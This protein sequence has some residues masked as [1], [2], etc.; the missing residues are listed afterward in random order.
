MTARATVTGR[1]PVY[2]LDGVNPDDL[3]GRV[4]THDDPASARCSLLSCCGELCRS[5]KGATVSG[6]GYG[7]VVAG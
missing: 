3:P 4:R 6:N 5:E 1:A 2:R 7:H